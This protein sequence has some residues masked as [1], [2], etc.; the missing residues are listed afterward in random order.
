M[1]DSNTQVGV[2]KFSDR[3]ELGFHLSRYDNVDDMVEAIE[4]LD[5]SGG[6]TNIA[7]ALRTARSQMFTP[8]NGTRSGD[9]PRLLIL[10]T[11]GTATEESWATIPEANLT[12]EAG[13][14]TF[15][16]GIGTDID[17]RQLKAIATAPWE[18]HYFF[19]ADFGALQLVVQDV[20]DRW[21]DESDKLET[22][23]TNAS[24]IATTQPTT[25]TTTTTSSTTTTPTKTGQETVC[26][27]G[28]TTSLGTT[29]TA[30]GKSP[31]CD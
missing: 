4:R 6:D 28:N 2:L 26:L 16:V 24:T 1:F 19:V 8:R 15:T 21:C 27:T 22:L 12:K 5:I 25:T 31:K 18:T 20:L 30:D 3:V 14:L 23:S 10:V 17:E 13:I 11:D 7:L 29:P 9:V